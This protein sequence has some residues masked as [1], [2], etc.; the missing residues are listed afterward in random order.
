MKTIRELL[1]D[2]TLLYESAVV[3]DREIAEAQAAPPALSTAWQIKTHARLLVATLR[4]QQT[5]GVR[6]IAPQ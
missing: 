2:A 5:P 6:P 4:D 3:L 1:D